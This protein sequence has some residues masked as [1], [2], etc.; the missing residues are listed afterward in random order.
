MD[1]VLGHLYRKESV[2]KL[3]IIWDPKKM[4]VMVPASRM[5]MQTVGTMVLT[6]KFPFNQAL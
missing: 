2:L 3:I 6:V 5:N 1:V 4:W